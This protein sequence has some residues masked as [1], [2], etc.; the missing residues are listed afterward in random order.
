MFDPRT[1]TYHNGVM[2][3]PLVVVTGQICAGKSALAA[4]LAEALGWQHV[5]IDDHAGDWM[6]YA[7]ALATRSAPLVAESVVAPRERATLHVHV[8]CD[9]L[10]R[11]RRLEARPRE[12]PR[13]AVAAYEY[14]GRA[15]VLVDT[16]R[17]TTPDALASLVRIAERRSLLRPTRA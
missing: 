11:Q 7:S 17:P 16:T 14:V 4:Q 12:M 10:E 8:R 15:D 3:T 5:G 2:G 1:R 13:T 6:A 9:E